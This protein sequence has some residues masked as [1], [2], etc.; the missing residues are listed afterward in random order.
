MTLS[1]Q[2][3]REAPRG[4]IQKCLKTRDATPQQVRGVRGR[5]HDS[6]TF[7]TFCELFNNLLCLCHPE[8]SEGS[9]LSSFYEIRDPSLRSG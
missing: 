1:C 7:L 4:G 2:P 8:R 3:R 6:I 5:W 9:P